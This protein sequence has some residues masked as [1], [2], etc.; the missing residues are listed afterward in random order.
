[1]AMI[2]RSCWLIDLEAMSSQATVV[3]RD[4]SYLEA[5]CQTAATDGLG[6][7]REPVSAMVKHGRRKHVAG[8]P[9]N[10]IQVNMHMFQFA[11]IRGKAVSESVRAANRSRRPRDRI[12]PAGMTPTIDGRQTRVDFRRTGGD[13]LGSVG[14]R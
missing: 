11:R 13:A 3:V 12:Q 1:M 5:P 7:G 10:W 14:R 4:G 6:K 9:A 2:I 8:E